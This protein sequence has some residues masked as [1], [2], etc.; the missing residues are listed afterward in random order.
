MAT[1]S[2][3]GWRQAQR[4][5][6]D[7]LDAS[8]NGDRRQRETR[9]A[10]LVGEAPMRSSCHSTAGASTVRTSFA[11]VGRSSIGKLVAHALGRSM[12]TR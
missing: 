4:E 2:T 3:R 11:A 1:G 8:F 12:R 7:R 10:L 9:R 5:D 6:G